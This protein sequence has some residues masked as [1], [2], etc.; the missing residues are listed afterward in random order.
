MTAK[1][2]KDGKRG[3]AAGA[4]TERAR[5]AEPGR[6]PSGHRLAKRLDVRPL[7][8]AGIHPVEQ[9]VR[10]LAA[11]APGDAYELV[12]PHVPTPVLERAAALGLTSET[13]EVGPGEFVTT[14]TR[15]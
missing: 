12:T 4:A 5:P 9:V 2:S 10:E 7:K 13:V 11:L 15:G 1:P 3:D 6:T 8:A 14:F